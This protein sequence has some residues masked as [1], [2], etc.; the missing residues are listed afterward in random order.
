MIFIPFH[1]AIG[2]RTVLAVIIEPANLDRMKAADPITL[3][4]QLRG[5]VMH[6]CLTQGTR[7]C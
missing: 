6:T 4:S 2:Q 7:L 5:G 3:E 1:E